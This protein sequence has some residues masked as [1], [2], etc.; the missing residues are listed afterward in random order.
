MDN[1]GID[2]YLQSAMEHLDMALD[3][4]R[5]LM[6]DEIAA[7]ET[8]RKWEEFFTHLFGNVRKETSA[9]VNAVQPD[10]DI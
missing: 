9:Y 10:E 5:L 4:T 2:G 8:A 6:Q 1:E 7:Q 3:K